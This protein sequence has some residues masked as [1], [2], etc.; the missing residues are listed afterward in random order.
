MVLHAALD[1]KGFNDSVN[2][3]KE[4]IALSLYS[5][6]QYDENNIDIDYYGDFRNKSRLE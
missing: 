4:L 3:R 1:S 6:L 5:I 2:L